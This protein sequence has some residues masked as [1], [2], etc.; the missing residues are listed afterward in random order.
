MKGDVHNEKDFK[1]DN[2]LKLNMGRCDLNFKLH[3]Y[4]FL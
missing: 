2:C 4:D 3:L 1:G